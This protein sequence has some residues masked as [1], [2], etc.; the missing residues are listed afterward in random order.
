STIGKKRYLLALVF[1]PLYILVY[2]LNNRLSS[3]AIIHMPFIPK[4]YRDNLLSVH[5]ENFT[6]GYFLQSFGYTCL[7]LL[8]ATSLYV[9]KI[10]FKNQH[11]L[12]TLQTEKLKLE[13]NH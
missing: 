9:V 6:H 11:T 8:A 3:F 2:E 12:Y 13:L 1:F 5:P 10:L 7:V 4:G